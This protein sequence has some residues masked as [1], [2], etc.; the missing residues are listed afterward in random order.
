MTGSDC[1]AAPRQQGHRLRYLEI[2]FF[3]V[4]LIANAVVNSL[5]A[6]SNLA[7]LGDFI[8]PW[9]PFSWEFTSIIAIAC[10]IPAIDWFN[11]CYPLTRQSWK[12]LLPLHA[13][14]TVPFSIIHVAVMV[15]LRK[16]I[17]VAAGLHYD[18][19]SP[20][21][22]WLYEYR[23]DVVT[24]AIIL[25]V[26]FAFDL[27]RRTRN[28]LAASSAPENDK[29][30]AAPERLVARKFGREFIVNLTDVDHIQ[31]NGN[32]VTL[33][34]GDSAYPLRESLA[35]LE[36]RLD[37]K[38]FARVHRSHL[39]NIERVREIRPWD[40]G[41]YRIVLETGTEVKLSRRYRSRL[42]AHF[43]A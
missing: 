13:A 24:Y 21:G 35:S 32:Y 26:V 29:A 38:R 25:A 11:R 16:L 41:D 28:T 33:Y 15:G 20:L 34:A 22:N 2:T 5:T 7:R 39:V 40:N 17:Y 14:A 6:I 18:F 12:W 1:A 31:A 10:L 19:G 42:G 37:P 9:K 27:Y 36:R 43:G 4:F 3:A 23:K 8:S 30:A